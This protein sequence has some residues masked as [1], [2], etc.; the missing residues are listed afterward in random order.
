L[1][2]AKDL[3]EAIGIAAR[4]PGA[5]KGTVEVRPVMDLP[6]LPEAKM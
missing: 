2:E 4:I 3:D 6:D 1:I 5:K